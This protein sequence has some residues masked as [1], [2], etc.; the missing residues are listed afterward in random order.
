MKK[1]IIFFSFFLS[2]LTMQAQETDSLC[3]KHIDSY[4]VKTELSTLNPL[5]D[6]VIDLSMQS[7]K[8]KTVP[9]V[10]LTQENVVVCLDLSF[11]RIAEIPIE[12]K[13]LQQLV[14]L[15][16]S[17]NHYLQTLPH[18]LNQMPRLRI[19]RLADLSWN[20]AK[21]QQIRKQFPHIY[22]VF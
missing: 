22:F 11:N 17:G 16:L 4:L 6:S 3:C 15:D 19:I 9:S 21:K 7:P 18:I 10:L 2:F 1:H 14:S 20:A 13:N 8:L 12:F 5:Q